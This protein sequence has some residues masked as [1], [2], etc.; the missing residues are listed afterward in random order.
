M[1]K[2]PHQRRDEP[3]YRL[4]RGHQIGADAL[5]LADRQQ[6]TTNLQDVRRL[7]VDLQPWHDTQAV[8]ELGEQL[9]AVAGIQ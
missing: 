8:K 5:A 3:C 4:I 6:V 2:R 7:R 9:A 1:P